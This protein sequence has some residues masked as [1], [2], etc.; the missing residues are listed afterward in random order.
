VASFLDSNVVL[1]ALGDDERKRAIALSLLARQPTISTQVINECSH[2]LRRK[3]QLGPA[4]LA[5]VLEDVI[6]LTRVV[7]VGLE[8]IRQAW[9]IAERHRY[10][11]YDS[12]IVATALSAGCSVLYTEDIQ[13]GQ[14][15]DGRVTVV[16]PFREP[17][18]AQP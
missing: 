5:S 16:D 13:N 3:Q 4:E 12:L 1:Y 18:A 15:F 17:P 7:D 8:Q 6:R 9:A 2:A 11:H 14:V 10:G